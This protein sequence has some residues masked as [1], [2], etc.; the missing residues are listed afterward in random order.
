MCR[1]GL[2][3]RC[4]A[5]GCA[6]FS[7]SVPTSLSRRPTCRAPPVEQYRQFAAADPVEVCACTFRVCACELNTHENRGF[8]VGGAGGGMRGGARAGEGMFKVRAWRARLD[9]HVPRVPADSVS[10]LFM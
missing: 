4:H 7:F 10:V 2:N 9:V 6:A 3:V 1:F 5:A 8:R